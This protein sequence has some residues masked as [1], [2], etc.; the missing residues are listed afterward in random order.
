VQVE[1][2]A[3]YIHEFLH[4]LLLHAVLELTR[5]VLGKP[6]GRVSGDRRQAGRVH[7]ILVHF[8]RVLWGGDATGG[9]CRRVEGWLM[10]LEMEM[11]GC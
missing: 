7:D 9:V 2:G 5:L 8:E 3:A 6:G 4:L 11:G 1:C 10:G